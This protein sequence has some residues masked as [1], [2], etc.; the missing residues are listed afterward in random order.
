[1]KY[2]FT[3]PLAVKTSTR[4]FKELTSTFLGG[5]DEVPHH[6]EMSHLILNWIT[7]QRLTEDRGGGVYGR[8]GSEE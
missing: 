6:A 3:G 7:A 5:V 4:S 1:M 8:S 2:S